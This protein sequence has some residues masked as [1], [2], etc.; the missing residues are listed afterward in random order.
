MLGYPLL[1]MSKMCDCS[2]AYHKLVVDVFVIF[3][4]HINQPYF[5]HGI[6][7]RLRFLDNASNNCLE[8]L[9]LYHAIEFGDVTHI[10]ILVDR[11]DAVQFGVDGQFR[12]TAILFG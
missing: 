7:V 12:Q 9:S 5:Q 2:A 11:C 4:R 6:I 8:F 1:L 3:L 10:P